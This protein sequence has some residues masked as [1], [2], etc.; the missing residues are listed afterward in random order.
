VLYTEINHP[1]QALKMQLRRTALVEAIDTI[2][3]TSGRRP[4]NSST[5]FNCVI[6][7]VAAA[8][9]K[10]DVPWVDRGAMMGSCEAARLSTTRRFDNERRRE[11]VEARKLGL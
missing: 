1:A 5:G 3:K 4:R 11:W 9:S 6:E 2:E 8:M 7:D 10:L